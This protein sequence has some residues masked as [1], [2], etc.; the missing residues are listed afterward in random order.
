MKKIQSAFILTLILS[1]FCN[2]N[3]AQITNDKLANKT[4]I[5]PKGYFKILPPDGWQKQEFSNE[6]RGKVKFVRSSP[7]GTMLQVIAGA[8]PFNNLEE[9]IEDSKRAAS[10]LKQNYGAITNIEKTS[11]AGFQAM[12]FT[13][14]IPNKLKQEQIQFILGGNH[15]TLVYGAPPNSFDKFHLIALASLETIEPILKKITK[16]E[17]YKHVIASKIRTA[18]NL[19]Q[20]GQKEYALTIINEGL[21]IDQNNNDLLELKKS[22][23]GQ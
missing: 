15:Y 18:K 11:F 8:S 3:F 17:S 16:E 20:L 9:L 5:D 1:I 12:R 4:Y 19:I 22:I 23:S 2:I 21:S 10:R 7:T 6:P 14:E 13:L